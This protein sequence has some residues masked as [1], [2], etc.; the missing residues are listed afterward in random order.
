MKL[1][2]VLSA[3]GRL[4][5]QSMVERS[6]QGIKV[7]KLPSTAAGDEEAGHREVGATD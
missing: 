6:I 2:E 4:N 1:G 7:L 5:V 3:E